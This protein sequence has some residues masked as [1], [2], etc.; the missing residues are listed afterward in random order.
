VAAV[1]EVGS[2]KWDL[3]GPRLAKGRLEGTTNM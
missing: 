3:K 2:A 1:R